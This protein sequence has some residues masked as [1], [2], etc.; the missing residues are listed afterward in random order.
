MSSVLRIDDDLLHPVWRECK[1]EVELSQEAIREDTLNVRV[2]IGKIDCHLE[3][4]SFNLDGDYRAA[5]DRHR[6]A[7]I[8]GAES[9]SVSSRADGL[10]VQ[11]V[12]EFLMKLAALVGLEVNDVAG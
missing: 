4:C 8:T 1:A 6:S 11:L 5:I 2:Q 12:G 10:K 3:H 9:D 7:S